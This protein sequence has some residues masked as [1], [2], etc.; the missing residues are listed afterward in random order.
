MVEPIPP[1]ASVISQSVT[2]MLVFKG[3]WP[4]PFLATQLCSAPPWPSMITTTHK[5]SRPN[6]ESELEPDSKSALESRA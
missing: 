1:R 2:M 3:T 6:S 5:E 4:R